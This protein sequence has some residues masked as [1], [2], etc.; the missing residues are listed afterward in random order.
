MLVLQRRTCFMVQKLLSQCGY[1]YSA[2]EQIIVVEC[3]L[4]QHIILTVEAFRAVT[5]PDSCDIRQLHASH[6]QG[7]SHLSMSQGTTPTLKS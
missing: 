1:R 5:D 7:L 3:V 2:R 6:I 4:S